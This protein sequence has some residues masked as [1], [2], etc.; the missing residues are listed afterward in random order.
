M[1]FHISEGV[2]SVTH[3]SHTASGYDD[4]I[5]KPY[6]VLTPY[7]RTVV[8]FDEAAERRS[9]HAELLRMR[10]DALWYAKRAR[11]ILVDRE[12]ERRTIEHNDYQV[13]LIS[14]RALPWWRRLCGEVPTPPVY[15]DSIV[16]VVEDQLS[17]D[18][19]WAMAKFVSEVPMEYEDWTDEVTKT[20]YLKIRKY[21][22]NGW[23]LIPTPKDL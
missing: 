3:W 6:Q 14:Y 7:K 4:V 8:V 21:Q 19:D 9:F 18:D 22:R 5:S 2:E 1:H 13:A 16:S 20:Q 15:Y 12:K 17:R 10:S 23:P 11:A